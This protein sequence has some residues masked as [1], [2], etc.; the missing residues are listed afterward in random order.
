MLSSACSRAID[1]AVSVKDPIGYLQVRAYRCL[2]TCCSVHPT[3]F[4]TR[5]A[6]EIAACQ[7]QCVHTAI[8]VMHL[9]D[10]SH[11]PVVLPL[12]VCVCVCVCVFDAFP[13]LFRAIFKAALNPQQ[14]P[15]RLQDELSQHL[16]R[17]LALFQAMLD[18]PNPGRWHF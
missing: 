7:D 5:G 14:K 10:Y 16:P 1:K 2:H 4:Y 13:Q 17:A 8:S 3:L 11:G 15:R 6:T 9:T 18:G 12:C